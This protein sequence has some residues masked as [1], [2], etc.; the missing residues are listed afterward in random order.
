MFLHLE[1][2]FNTYF[3]ARSNV[4]GKE[5]IF[6]LNKG[7]KISTVCTLHKANYLRK[8]DFVETMNALNHSPISIECGAETAGSAKTQE[9]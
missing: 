6:L 7:L 2:N 3:V 9:L 4:D 8:A 5:I 1:L